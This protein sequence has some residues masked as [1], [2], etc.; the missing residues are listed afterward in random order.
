MIPVVSIVGKSNSGKTTLI[1][2]LIPSLKARGYK[3]GAIKHD[4]HFFDIDHE[5]KDTWRMTRAGA[6]NVVISSKGKIAMIK[7]VDSEKN[8]NEII[9]WLFE[10]VDIVIT[11]GYKAS[12]NPKIEVIRYE[13]PVISPSDNLLAIINNVSGET[14]LNLPKGYEQIYMLPMNDLEKII[15]LIES[16]ILNPGD[17]SI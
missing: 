5:G 2:R 11:E 7:T 6:D 8:L 3:V 12:D 9:Y 13:K 1:E 10:D 17:N 4:A 15:H 14:T 16:K